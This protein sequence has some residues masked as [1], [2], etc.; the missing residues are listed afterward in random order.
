MKELN[1]LAIVNSKTLLEAYSEF[2][3]ISKMEFFVS[4]DNRFQPLT[5]FAEKLLPR[6]FTGL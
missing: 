1:N 6:C 5:I 4:I 3:Q 2:F